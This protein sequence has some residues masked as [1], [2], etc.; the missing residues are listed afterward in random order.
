[1]MNPE[2]ST[3]QRPSSPTNAYKVQEIAMSSP[4]KCILHLYDVAIQSCALEQD[5][6]ARQA[7]TMLIDGLNFDD[8]GDVATK[9]FMLYD[10]CLRLVHKKKFDV[11]R[12]VLQGLRETW[13]KALTNE[14][15]A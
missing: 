12:K 2:T 1:M 6:R 8:G 11:P 15:A 4:E 3:Q 10:Y 5:E 14:I 9:L 7:L 13:Q